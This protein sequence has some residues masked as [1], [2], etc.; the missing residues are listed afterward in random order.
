LSQEEQREVS[1]NH[2]T[3]IADLC[4]NYEEIS[5]RKTYVTELPP[6]MCEHVAATAQ[7]LAAFIATCTDAEA[8]Q[9]VLKGGPNDLDYDD[10]MVSNMRQKKVDEF[11]EEVLA[12]VVANNSQPGLTRTD[13]RNQFLKQ[14]KKAL[15]MCMS[16]H[17][18]VLVVGNS[19]FGRIKIPT[20]I[21]CDRPLLEKVRQESVTQADDSAQRRNFAPFG[22]G[23]GGMG[24]GG[25]LEDP[26]SM[27]SS[28]SL[29]S[30]T[31]PPKLRVRGRAA[32]VKLPVARPTSSH[33]DSGVVSTLRGGLKIPRPGS[34]NN[35]SAN[36]EEGGARHVPNGLSLQQGKRSLTKG[37]SKV[38]ISKVVMCT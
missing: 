4:I 25:Q 9:K 14:T 28:L 37:H 26:N 7:A 2:A 30:G 23:V 16:K 17:D 33:G 21:A 19:R 15:Q 32:K 34:S 1:N 22:G 6:T 31:S 35:F 12:I 10:T 29:V 13:A 3:F 27:A 8:I 11:L 24:G 20:C 38:A 18:Q 36:Q 5:V